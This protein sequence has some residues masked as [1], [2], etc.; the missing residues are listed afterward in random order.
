MKATGCT[1]VDI[2][3]HRPAAPVLIETAI[4]GTDPAV[5]FETSRYFDKHSQPASTIRLVF[6]EKACSS[7]HVSAKDCLEMGCVGNR[8]AGA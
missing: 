7:C 3:R 5:F 2:A 6:W 4:S 8:W 1:L